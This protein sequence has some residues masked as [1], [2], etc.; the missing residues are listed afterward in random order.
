MT[1]TYTNGTHNKKH[2]TQLHESFC[3]NLLWFKTS[4]KV[5]HWVTNKKVLFST[6][7]KIDLFYDLKQ[8]IKKVFIFVHIHEL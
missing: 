1:Q 7:E 8:D 2:N 6:D 3:I 4:N 5:L